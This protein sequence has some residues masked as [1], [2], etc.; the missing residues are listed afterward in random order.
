MCPRS[1]HSQPHKWWNKGTGSRCDGAIPAV[2]QLRAAGGP[3]GVWQWFPCTRC[4][5]EQG[6]SPYAAPQGV[7]D[8]GVTPAWPCLVMAAEIQLP[9]VGSH[10]CVRRV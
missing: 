3:D 2:R 6:P 10:G 1:R 9:P 4:R 5:L 8:P 7:G